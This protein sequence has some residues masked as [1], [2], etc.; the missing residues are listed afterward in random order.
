MQICPDPDMSQ[1]QCKAI[2]LSPQ[3]S[4]P[5]E[6]LIFDGNQFDWFNEA[7]G[8]LH[9]N[10][11]NIR[12]TSTELVRL[13]DQY[14]YVKFFV[15]G[16]E[17]FTTACTVTNETTQVINE[18][19]LYYDSNRRKF[20][21]QKHLLSNTETI[22]LVPDFFTQA[23]ENWQKI[24]QG[25]QKFIHQLK[26]EHRYRNSLSSVLLIKVDYTTHVFEGGV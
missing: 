19:V 21:I 2:Y 1:I 11:I 24:Q 12:H 14:E 22:G 5:E 18:P 15:N 13:L 10:S 6:I 26:K 9:F 16:E 3:T 20:Y 25:W 8:E 23:E 17:A 7:T 4:L